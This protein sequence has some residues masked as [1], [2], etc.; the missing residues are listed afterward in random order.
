M[1][2]D[3]QIKAIQDIE[4]AIQARE[5]M[6]EGLKGMGDPASIIYHMEQINAAQVVWDQLM[7][8]EVSD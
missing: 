4:Y 3:Q 1:T 8:A 5:R 6:I 7:E 2:R